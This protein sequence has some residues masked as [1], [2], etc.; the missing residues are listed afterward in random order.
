MHIVLHNPEIPENTGNIGR[1]CVITNSTLHLIEP[2]GFKLNDKMI[3]RAGLD[4]WDKLKV[5]RYLNYREFLDKT[6]AD[7]NSHNS[8]IF[9][10][11]TKGAVP[12]SSVRYGPHDYIMFGKESG[13]IPV[14]ILNTAPQ[15]CIRIPMY[16]TERSLNL[17]NSVSII[18]YEGLRQN[19]FPGLT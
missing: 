3:K 14:E 1:T 8:K 6:E 2:L 5:E 11:T 18:L 16:N 9:F 15:N 12:Y 10:A 19:D 13:G 7:R 4:Y 17:A